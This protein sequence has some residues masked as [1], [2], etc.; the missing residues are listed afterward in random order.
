MVGRHS[1]RYHLALS[2]ARPAI[3]S[4]LVGLHIPDWCLL[5]SDAQT[6]DN[7]SYAYFFISWRWYGYHPSWALVD[8]EH[9][10]SS[11]CVAG[12]SVRVTLFKRMVS[13]NRINFLFLGFLL[14]RKIYVIRDNV[15]L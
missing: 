8:C 5:R 7:A 6:G 10:H 1:V 15:I 11:W 2:A 13:Q 4:R 14:G 9:S 3:Q 12:R